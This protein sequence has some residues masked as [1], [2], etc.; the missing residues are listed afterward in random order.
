M[1]PEPAAPDWS[2]IDTV[3]IDMDGTLLDLK[4]DNWFWQDHVPDAWGAGR[5]LDV[6]T[7]AELLRPRFEAVHGR[8]DWYCIDYWSRELELDIRAM[9]LAQS[10]RIVW[11][12]GAQELLARL[13]TLGKQRVLVTNSHPELLAIKDRRTGVTER[14]DAA[15]SSHTFGVPKE[16]PEFWPRFAAAHHFDP[17][18]TLLVD[19]SLP[20]LKAA[21]VAGV[22]WQTAIRRPDS[23]DPP[24][25]RAGFH[26]LDSIAELV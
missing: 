25:E 3:L 9:T 21:R 1:P 4:F 23:R 8:L 20:V 2:R 17:A 6:R 19:D 24:R 15:F 12:D 13:G 5:G 22:G 26:G 16:D 11:I 14:V 7:A 18:R 10:E